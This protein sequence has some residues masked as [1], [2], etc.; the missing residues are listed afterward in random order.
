MYLT[1]PKKKTNRYADFSPVTQTFMSAVE[2]H[3]TDKFSKIE[4]Q[5]DGLLMMLAD[6]YE[7]FFDCRAQIKKD[8]L[9]I[10]NRF[11]NWD[12]HPLIKVQNDAQIQIVKLVQEFGISPKAIS[13]LTNITEN[14]EDDFIKALTA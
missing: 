11:G 4:T 3:L 7:L 13:R 12:K 14:N 9:M 6:N 5:W 10:Q 2:K 1:M 8:G